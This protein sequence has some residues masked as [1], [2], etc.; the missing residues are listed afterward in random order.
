MGRITGTRV[1][2]RMCEA[3]CPFHQ[4]FIKAKLR[5]VD[6]IYL[7]TGDNDSTARLTRLHDFDLTL[8]SASA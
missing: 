7:P 4:R 3:W 6:S 5:E 1:P 8:I 2:Q